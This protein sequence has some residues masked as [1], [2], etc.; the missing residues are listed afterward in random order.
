VRQAQAGGTRVILCD[1][2]RPV[3]E[4]LARTHP[5]FAGAERTRTLAAAIA[6]LERGPQSST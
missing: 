4:T 3:W 5:R 1:M 2:A 6:R